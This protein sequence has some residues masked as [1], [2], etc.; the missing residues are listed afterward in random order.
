MNEGM[1]AILILCEYTVWLPTVTEPTALGIGVDYMR[2][3]RFC[4]ERKKKVYIYIH[5]S[6]AVEFHPTAAYGI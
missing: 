2:Q 5:G 3:S 6:M 4:D 1:G